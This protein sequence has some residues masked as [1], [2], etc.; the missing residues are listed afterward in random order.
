MLVTGASGLLGSAI[1]KRAQK[2][3][4]EFMGTF[5]KHPP[6]GDSYASHFTRMDVSSAT[7]V[8]KVFELFRPDVVIHS[9][10]ITD[11][12]WCEQNAR[13]AYRINA[14]G[15]LNI[16][17]ACNDSHAFLAYVSSDYVF[18][19]LRGCYREEDTPNPLLQ[20]GITKLEGERLVKKTLDVHC[21][22]RTSMLFGWGGRKKNLATLVIENLK[23]RLPFKAL[24]DQI[25]SASYDENVAAMLIEIVQR[26]IAG[27]LNVAGATRLT[28]LDFCMMLARVFGLDVS[29]ISETTID[30]MRLK[31][32]RPKNIGLDVSKALATLSV[33]PL[34]A[35][36]SLM[37]M[38]C[39]RPF[40][41]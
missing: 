24:K 15:T 16:A 8:N 12:E 22:A 25:V 2:T 23:N 14:G 36:D 33:R 13:E 30:S 17:R 5:L 18:D 29:L 38:Y 10:A 4:L 1:V 20:Y 21:I 31:A 28:R 6:Q 26:R 19:G 40:T 32:T 9:A 37:N 41:D 35:E 39:R 34:T 7:E 27:H 11:I 3:G